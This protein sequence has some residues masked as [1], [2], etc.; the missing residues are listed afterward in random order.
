MKKPILLSA[1]LSASLLV[2]AQAA[3]AQAAPAGEPAPES[4]ELV[5]DWYLNVTTISMF[6]DVLRADFIA[7]GTIVRIENPKFPRLVFQPDQY[8]SGTPLAEN[9]VV[10]ETGI[11]ADLGELEGKRVVAG[12]VYRA[13]QNKYGL[14]HGVQS[15]TPEG[16][17]VDTSVQFYRDL[18]SAKAEYSEQVEA[19]LEANPKDGKF[20]FPEELTTKLVDIF[21][22]YMGQTG[23]QAAHHAARELY[24][25]VMFEGKLTEDHLATIASQALESDA[26]TFDR[27]YSYMLLTRAES[28][29]LSLENCIKLIK[30]ETANV[31]LD[32]MVLY[33]H[34]A[35]EDDAVVEAV[36]EVMTNVSFTTDERHN[37]MQIASRHRSMGFLPAMHARLGHETELKLKRVLLECYRN[38]PDV[39][40]L[41]PLISYL[42]GGDGESDPYAEDFKKIQE[43]CSTSR[44]LFKRAM[45]GIA[46]IDTNIDAE[47]NGAYEAETDEE[48][49][50]IIEASV[51]E[52]SNAFLREAYA[53]AR[54]PWVRDFL[55]H[56][57]PE[58]KDWR[59]VI[60]IQGFEDTMPIVPRGDEPTDVDSTPAPGTGTPTTPP[61]GDGS[62][63]PGN[64]QNPGTGNGG[65]NTGNGESTD[66][67]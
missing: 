63:T 35:F 64:G 62:N 5:H 46:M 26:G 6:T 4:E 47:G 16:F 20:A 3:L 41:K 25:N 33:M 2:G 18:L 21:V 39:S 38:H 66:E 13:D 65:A 40:N 29:A 67:E 15:L 51:K 24:S 32:N 57:Q 27:G 7:T 48:R 36:S 56:L 28:D 53:Q 50:A 12:V 34:S 59:K 9:E 54:F 19:A 14:A 37:A 43:D 44:G 11:N 60:Q 42:S 55:F 8:L 58:N 49:D 45:L 23:T 1:L 30:N 61:I 31:N 10:L 17:G 22:E 52:S